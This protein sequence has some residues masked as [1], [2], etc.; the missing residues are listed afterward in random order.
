MYLL[1][2]HVCVDVCSSKTKYTVMCLSKRNHMRSVGLIGPMG[3]LPQVKPFA[4]ALIR[5]GGDRGD[6]NDAFSVYG[7]DD[8]EVFPLPLDRSNDGSVRKG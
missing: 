2:S 5:R 8:G 1:I 7:M 3:M 6:R 4:K